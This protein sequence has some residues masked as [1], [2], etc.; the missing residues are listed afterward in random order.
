MK[1][2]LAIVWLGVLF[3]IIG[4]IFWY[5]EYVYSLPTPVPSNYTKV[6]TGEQ[7]KLIPILNSYNNGKPLLLH[8][9]NPDCP[10]S[11]FNIKHFQSLVHQ[12]NGDVNFAVVLM[13]AKGYT[14]DQVKKKFDLNVPVIFSPETAKACGVYSTP[15]AAIIDASGKL[16]Y[17]G[18]Y[19]TNRYCTNTQTEYARIALEALL[20]NNRTIHFNQ[21]ALT[22]YG[23]SLPDCK[24]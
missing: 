3:T 2:M 6:A 4:F 17:R 9:F 23:C 15:Q 18:N 24:K 14:P 22:A 10:C 16:F 5:N 19:N 11:K 12:F 8:F 1:K 21:L 20:Q 7:I 13:S